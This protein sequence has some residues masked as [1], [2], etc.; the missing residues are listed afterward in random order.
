MQGPYLNFCWTQV[1]EPRSWNALLPIFIFQDI[2]M[3]LFP[4]TFPSISFRLSRGFLPPPPPSPQI[5]RWSWMF[6]FHNFNHHS[7]MDSSHMWVLTSLPS[8]GSNFYLPMGCF[9]LQILPTL[10]MTSL[11]LVFMISFPKTLLC[12]CLTFPFQKNCIKTMTKW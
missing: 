10:A 8:S 7:W 4:P 5:C 11:Q 2:M 1:I 3:L 12:L 6:Y 9:Y